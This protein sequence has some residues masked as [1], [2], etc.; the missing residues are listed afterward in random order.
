M[1][2]HVVTWNKQE[3][4]LEEHCT[5]YGVPACV[6]ISCK[7]CVFFLVRCFVYKDCVYYIFIMPKKCLNHSDTFPYVC[8]ELTFKSPRW[9]FTPFVNKCYDLYFGCEVCVQN[10]CWGPHICCVTCV[11]LHTGWLNGSRQTP[12]P[13]PMLWMEL[14]DP[15]SH[16]SFVQTT[17]QGSPSNPNTVKYPD[18]PSTMTPVP[19]RYELLVPNL[20]ENQNFSNGNSDCGEDRGQQKYW[21]WSDIWSKMFLIWT[22]LI[23]T[24]KS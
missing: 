10:K 24:R 18:L 19:H 6:V 1:Y 12:F 7:C 16:C 8:G 11:G 5:A 23:N 21:L 14:E 3:V 9:N 17:W 13:F 22:T 15:S 2:W 20:P 4:P